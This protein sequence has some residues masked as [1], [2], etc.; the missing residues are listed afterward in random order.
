MNTTQKK[1]RLQRT[2]RRN[3]KPRSPASAAP[4]RGGLEESG[5]CSSATALSLRV[6]LHRLGV[7]R[8]LRGERLPRAHRGRRVAGVEVRV[9]ELLA[10][11]LVAGVALE[12]LFVSLGRLAELAALHELVPGEHGVTRVLQGG[13]A[14]AA[15]GVRGG[16]VA[17]P[18]ARR[19]AHEPQRR[20]GIAD[21]L[22]GSGQA[23]AELRVSGAEVDGTAEV[24]EPEEI[25]AAREET[26][27]PLRLLARGA[28][29]LVGRPRHLVPD[30]G[31]L[32]GRE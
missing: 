19:L 31:E 7:E 14:G 5:G 24:G 30:D 17:G 10:S 9:A 28:A 16:G 32:L 8:P 2:W 23:Q 4:M 25:L 27:R 12:R 26:L 13:E 6:E 11:V 1:I 29:A 18:D 3:A 15:G 22:E 21:V 20:V